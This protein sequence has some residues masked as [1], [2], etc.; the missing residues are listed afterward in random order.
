MFEL[1]HNGHSVRIRQLRDKW[2][3]EIKPNHQN[4]LRMHGFGELSEECAVTEAKGAIDHWIAKC[5]E[6]ELKR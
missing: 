1:Q 6:M 5:R 3:Y 4:G 2:E